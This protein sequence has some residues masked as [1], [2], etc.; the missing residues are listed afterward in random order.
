MK[1]SNHLVSP[2]PPKF[3]MDKLSKYLN[4]GTVDMKKLHGGDTKPLMNFSEMMDDVTFIDPT[5][6]E[7]EQL[8]IA[9]YNK[10]S[11]SSNKDTTSFD[12]VDV[13]SG[14]LESPAIPQI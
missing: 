1:G 4:F 14:S 2:K 3:E 7:N 10:V 8:R 9:S 11:K 5:K 12:I 6:K 13:N